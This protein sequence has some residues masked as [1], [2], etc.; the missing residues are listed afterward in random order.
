[1]IVP[2][3]LDRCVRVCAFGLLLSL[4]G[5]GGIDGEAVEDL[6][7]AVQEIRGTYQADDG[8]QR[9][10][11]RAENL[12]S[13]HGVNGAVARVITPR[14]NVCSGTLV[15]RRHVLTAGHCTKGPEDSPIE[16]FSSKT[17]PRCSSRSIASYGARLGRA[18]TVGGWT[19][20]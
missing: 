18:L 10:I 19:L 15:S 1:M 11:S 20:L 16:V 2:G 17:H 5:C 14:K 4:I 7:T 13:Q 3:R 9:P 6:G 12:T 8:S